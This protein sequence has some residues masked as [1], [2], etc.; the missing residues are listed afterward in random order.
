MPYAPMAANPRCYLREQPGLPEMGMFALRTCSAGRE[1]S[2][3]R[4]RHCE[5]RVPVTE[6]NIAGSGVILYR[7]LALL[8][9][10]RPGASIEAPADDRAGNRWAW[11]KSPRHVS[12]LPLSPLPPDGADIRNVSTDRLL[13]LSASLRVTCVFRAVSGCILLAVHNQVCSGCQ[14]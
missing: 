8:N 9:L 3:S 13:L 11:P 5:S 6:T 14:P 4:W 10:E 12:T 2:L 1:V 7:R